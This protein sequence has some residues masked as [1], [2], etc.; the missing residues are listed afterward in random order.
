[1][2]QVLSPPASIQ[3]HF[4]DSLFTRLLFDTRRDIIV[5]EDCFP[6]IFSI[7]RREQELLVFCDAEKIINSGYLRRWAGVNCL[8]QLLYNC[9]FKP[10]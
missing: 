4:L 1:M 9:S 6:E 2:F 8:T 5:R 3:N 10:L 7:T